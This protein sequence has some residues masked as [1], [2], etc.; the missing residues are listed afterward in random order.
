MLVLGENPSSEFTYSAQS[1]PPNAEEKHSWNPLFGQMEENP[2]RKKGLGQGY[3]S[4]SNASEEE[5]K[6]LQFKV[7]HL[8]LII[9]FLW[10]W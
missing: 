10:I 9:F 5:E 3:V 1:P 2:A 6:V 8:L 4:R 7:G